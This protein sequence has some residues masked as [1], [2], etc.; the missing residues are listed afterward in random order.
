M[1]GFLL[2]PVR[3]QNV[4]GPVHSGSPEGIDGVAEGNAP[5]KRARHN[6]RP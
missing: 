2:L 5:G 4:L 3:P 6:V 1:K